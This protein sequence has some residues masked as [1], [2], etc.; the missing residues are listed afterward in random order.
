[1]T[2]YED[3]PKGE[4]PAFGSFTG[5][6]H[7]HWWVGNAKVMAD[8]FIVRFGFERVAYRGL[9]TGHRTMVSH[10]VRQGKI[11]FVFSSPI[12]PCDTTDE[13]CAHLSKHGDGVKDVAFGVPDCKKIF[14]TAVSRGAKAL[15]EPHV[16][17]DADGKVVMATVATYGDTVH[18]FVERTEYTGAFL[19][20]YKTVSEADP[21]NAVLPAAGLDIVDHIVGNM[22][23]GEME[24][25]V[26]WYLKVL[27]FHRFWSVD[28]KDIHTEFSSLRSVVVADYDEVIKM[29]INEPAVGK[30]KSQIQEFVEYYGGNGVQHIA[31]KT[32]DIIT[33][34][35]NLRARGVKFLKV[36]STYY[37]SLETRLAAAG[38]KVKEDMATIRELN[39]LVD[40][41]EKGYLLQLFTANVL[42]RPTVFLEII[43]REGNSGFG[44]G[45]FKSLFEAI[46]R[47]Q[48]ARGNLTE[49]A[50]A[51]AAA[52]ASAE[53]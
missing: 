25:T 19:P 51:A 30:R 31:L 14:D 41:D 2:S 7:V 38:I 26:S 39:I 48:E 24:T 27:E 5:F 52:A 21:V 46:E 40:F 50:P 8:W 28:D 6:D 1:M 42:D 12:N 23:D 22:G 49:T 29:P 11:V 34:I 33:A 10:V 20:N 43:Q 3:A 45:N 9:E 36:P 17:E 37:D 35:T 18:T 47:E 13:M 32:E 15:V 4:K 53:A 44:A 16:E